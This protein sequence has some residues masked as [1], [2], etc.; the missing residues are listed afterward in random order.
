MCYQKRNEISENEIKISRRIF[1]LR[2]SA[3]TEIETARIA[4]AMTAVDFARFA[5]IFLFIFSKISFL[6]LKFSVDC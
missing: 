3:Q 4:A 1:A 2:E 5:R 6:I